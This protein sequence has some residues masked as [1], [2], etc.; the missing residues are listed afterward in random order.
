MSF[1]ADLDNFL[2]DFGQDVILRRVIGT[3]AQV[4]ID[5][6]C[7]A[8]VRGYTADEIAGGVIL[9]GDSRVIIS[10][11]DI[12]RAQWPGGEPVQSPPVETDPRVPRAGD[13]VIV[14][15]RSRAVITASP[16]YVDGALLRIDA[17]VRG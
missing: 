16:T 11:T 15:G 12:E 8:W 6:P 7:R 4:N 9:Q 13:R 3:T 2:G 1:R 14:E 10:A 5:C 17:Q